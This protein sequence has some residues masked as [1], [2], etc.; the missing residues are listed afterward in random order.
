[1]YARRITSEQT[2]TLAE[3]RKIINKE[4]AQE[5]E[6]FLQ[7]VFQKFLGCMALV[8]S[9]TEIIAAYAGV[10]DEGGLCLFAIPFGIWLLFTKKNIL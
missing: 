3:A 9:A 6:I 2:Y 4:Y 10:I 7:K 1:M 5:R 8:A